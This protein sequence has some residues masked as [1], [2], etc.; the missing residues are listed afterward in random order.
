VLGERIEDMTEKDEALLARL[1]RV[2]ELRAALVLEA[3]SM[4]ALHLETD[5]LLGVAYA[6]ALHAISQRLHTLKLEHP[7]G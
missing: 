4:D 2:S 7:F 3:Q 1:E 5:P 6:N